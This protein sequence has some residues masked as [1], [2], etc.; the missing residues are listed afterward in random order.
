MLG[1]R[2]LVA[3]LAAA[4]SVVCLAAGCSVFDA[5]EGGEGEVFRTYFTADIPDLDSTTTADLISGDVLNNVMEGL[6]RVDGN[7]EPQPAIAE[8][9]EVSEDGKTY[10]FTL[11]EG[12]EWANG[13]PVTAGD[14]RYA[15]LRAINPD[16]AGDPAYL[17]YDYVEGGEEYFN[18]EADADE[19]GIKAPSDDT[20]VVELENPVPFFPALTTSSVFFPQN[21]EFVEEK[22]D[23]FALSG[24]AILSNGPYEVA[25][26]EP[27]NRVFLEKN[28]NYWDA[29]NVEIERVEARVIKDSETALNLY[30]AGDL[31]TVEL[32]SENV[33]R[34]TDSPEF[35]TVR[36]SQTY[37][38]YF[39]LEDEAMA[40]EDI[41][42]AVQT[43]FDKEAYVETILAD[44]SEAAYGLVPPP[45]PG[46]GG[47]SFR[48]ANGEV[49]PRFDPDDAREAWERGVEELG[50]E[51]ELTITVSDG[52]DSQDLGT[53]MESE[54]RENLGAEVGIET[55]PFDALFEAQDRGEFQMN[56]WSWT[57]GLDPVLHLELWTTDST[58]NDS[59]FSNERYDELIRNVR[60]EPDPDERMEMLAEA[61]RLLLEEGSALAPIYHPASASLTK[62]YVKPAVS[63]DE[64]NPAVPALDLKRMSLDR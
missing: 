48:E 13:D 14:F 6:F 47:E 5:D 7:F 28:E 60:S 58:I 59:G 9:F 53:F 26:L 61:E 56:A 20:L 27:S 31:D 2:M 42:R 39:N 54:F 8:S 35:A 16:T 51:P 18:G 55:M 21:R 22:G 43:A 50:R 29:E 15:W 12:V 63:E 4:V 38:L 30:E 17:I 19:V 49:V 52:S 25:A 36:N 34:F 40:N 24:D 45:I 64:L 23:E 41:R 33:G 57:A 44:G 37:F 10:T 32:T 62:P 46:P 11:R 1:R 3:W